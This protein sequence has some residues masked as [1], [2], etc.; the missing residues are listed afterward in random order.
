MQAASPFNDHA[1]I[2]ATRKLE[3]RE[4]AKITRTTFRHFWD[5]FLTHRHRVTQLLINV[6]MFRFCF[7]TRPILKLAYSLSI[8]LG[9]LT[10]EKVYGRKKVDERY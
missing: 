2:L 3:M 4:Q 5:N 6:S 7:V 1:T 9:E 8:G 10:L